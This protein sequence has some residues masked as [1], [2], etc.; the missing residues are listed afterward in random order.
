MFTVCP[1]CTLTLVVTTVDLRAGQG[2]VRCGR[3][4]NVFNALV[5]LREGDASGGI[6]DTANRRL[7]ETRPNPPVEPAHGAG[8]AVES[9]PVPEPA[10]EPEIEAETAPQPEQEQE[11]H[12]ET[13][14]L[15]SDEQ[16]MEFDAAA[17]DVSAIFV[18][19]SDNEHDTN[20]GNY[21]AVVLSEESPVGP[22]PEAPLVEETTDHP[23][24]HTMSSGDWS[25]ADDPGEN[26]SAS[27]IELIEE[28]EAASAED[29]GTV[30]ASRNADPAWVE[31]MFAE[32][33]AQAEA[34]RTRVAQREVPAVI[35]AAI[36]PA[37]AATVTRAPQ[38]TEVS[39][40]QTE[41][42]IA[43]LLTT[44]ASQ[45]PPWQ[46]VSAVAV[47]AAL[48]LGQILHHNRQTL[49]LSS[50]MGP[51]VTKLYGWFGVTLMPR[52]DLSAYSVKQL[53]AEAEGAEGTRLRVRL[54]LQNGSTRVQPL[55]LLR[56]TLQDRYGNAVA[57][58][59]LEPRDYLPKR[60]VEQR[61]L[62]PDQRID[63]ELHVI[64]PGKAA[65]SFEID[66]CLRAE[67][68]RIGCANEARRRAAG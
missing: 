63:A 6:S 25:L 53:G 8:V 1:K 14:V 57:T 50:G 32:A 15:D 30:G 58:R 21:E 10:A 44:P 48:L 20:S 13:I 11:S 26:E 18:S 39:A 60:V 42:A 55:P 34:K 37:A 7:L 2:Y 52:W 56:L 38:P 68:G 64:D 36:P 66:A 27:T 35:A 67:S 54:S 16:S 12:A 22:D 65:S 59:D 28:P 43:P 49:V 61:L 9:E 23:H 5:A 24:A 40:E 47:L 4:A 31:E 51:A 3:C 62:E 33:E 17:T 29:K 19:P 41:A 46:Y 45:R